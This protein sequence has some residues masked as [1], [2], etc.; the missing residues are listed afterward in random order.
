MHFW[1]TAKKIPM[2]NAI[3]TLQTMCA[4]V[5][6]ISTPIDNNKKKNCT[7]THTALFQK[8]QISKDKQDF[9]T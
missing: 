4:L 1:Q 9:L 8:I 6:F 7:D 2:I 3:F 5:T